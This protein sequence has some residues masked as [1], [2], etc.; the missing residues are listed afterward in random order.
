LLATEIGKQLEPVKDPQ[1]GRYFPKNEY[2]LVADLKRAMT[3]LGRARLRKAIHATRISAA[4]RSN[5][6]WRSRRALVLPQEPGRPLTTESH[7]GVHE[8]EVQKPLHLMA[9]MIART[10]TEEMRRPG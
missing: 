6:G 4:S 7:P 3:E 5:P 10:R 1:S 9:S 8:R 2:S